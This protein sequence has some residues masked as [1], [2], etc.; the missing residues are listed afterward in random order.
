MDQRVKNERVGFLVA[1]VS[2][3]YGSGSGGVLWRSLWGADQLQEW[4]LER[5]ARV[6][7]KNPKTTPLLNVIVVYFST[8]FSPFLSNFKPSF[9]TFTCSQFTN[10]EDKTQEIIVLVQRQ[11]ARLHCTQDGHPSRWFTASSTCLFNNP[12]TLK[13]HVK[14]LNCPI[15]HHLV[16]HSVLLNHVLDLSKESIVTPKGYNGFLTNWR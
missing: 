11:E 5:N 13:G 10:N 14:F 8:Y 15:R 9:F 7:S 6:P 2:T 3:E 1:S 16:D 12:R 4:W